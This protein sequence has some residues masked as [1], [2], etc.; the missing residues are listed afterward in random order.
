MRNRIRLRLT[1]YF[2]ASFL[3]FSTIIGVIFY[4][5]FSSYSANVHKAE[6]EKR[7]TNIAATMAG[8]SQSNM[9]HGQGMSGQGMGYGAYLHFI[10]D[11]AMSDVWLVDSNMAQITRGHEQASLYY[12]DLPL[13][14]ES[15]VKR[16]YP[17]KHLSAKILARFSIHQPSLLQ[18][19]SYYKTVQSPGRCCCILRWK[20]SR[21]LQTAGC[22]FCCSA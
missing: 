15:V 17:G 21:M 7:A 8:F 12:Q 13:G 20:T 22:S 19:P 4:F 5:L 18:R 11:I 9:G 16:L 10:E 14:A 2:G 6:L 3:L 1:L